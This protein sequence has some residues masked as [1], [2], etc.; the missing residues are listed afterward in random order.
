MTLT[1]LGKLVLATSLLTGSGSVLLGQSRLMKPAALQC[2]S[3]TTPLGIDS[4]QPL[5]SWKLQDSRYGARQSAYQVQVGADMNALADGKADVWDSGR[6]ASNKSVG[7]L[8]GGPSLQPEKRYYWRVRVWDQDGDEYPPSDVSWWETGLLESQHWRGKWIG[9]EEDEHRRLREAGAAWITNA[10]SDHS[11]VAG[12]THHQFRFAFDLPQ[13]AKHAFLYVTGEDSAAAWLDGKQVLKASPFPAWHQMPWKTY[14]RADITAEVH[15][16]KN[17]LA[18]DVVL[19][20]KPRTSRPTTPMSA[21]LYV[22]DSG[23]SAHIFKTGDPGWRAAL[24][25]SGNW[26]AKAFNDDSW[27]PAVPF[28]APENR[29]L[30]SEPM[31]KPWPTGSVMA[32]RRVFQVSKPIASARLYA[33]SLG[34]YEFRLNGKRVGD[35]IL[36]PGWMD[37]RQHV[38]YQVYDVTDLLKAG[39]NSI[40]VLLAPG[41]YTTPLLWFQQGYNYGDT[42]PAV[43]A[44]LRIEHPDGSLDWIATDDSWK[45]DVSPIL[46]A[47]I[48]DGETYDARRAQAGWD[49]AEFS[50]AKWKPVQ[51]I[52]PNEPKIVAQYFPPIREQSVLKAQT[53]TSPRP[54]VYIYDFGQNL[55]GVPRI[56]V[57]GPRGTDVQLRFAEVLNP[58]GSLYV[59]NLRTAKVTDHYILAGK[60]VEEYQPAF[61]FHGFRYAEISGL[62]SKPALDAVKAVVLHTDAPFTARLKTGSSM[63]NQLWSNILWGQRS[64]F[65][66][67][68][69]D[70]PQRDERLGWTGDAQ[71]FWRT[72]S[73]NMD[74]TTFSQKYA[75]DVRGTQSG[76]AMYGIFAPGALSANPGYAT[77]WSD[78]GVIVPWTSWMQTA[79]TRV[80]EENWDA[81]QKYLSAILAENPDY[82]RKKSGIGLGDWLAPEGATAVDLIAT[83]YWAYDADLMRQMAGAIGKSS[84]AR[85]YADLFAKIKAAFNQAYVHSDGFVGAVPSTVVF[86]SGTEKQLPKDPVD[87]QTGY[88]LAL[89]MNLLQ[90]SVRPLAAQRL[91]DRIAKNDWRLAT[92]FLGTPYLLEALT[93]T[94]HGDVAYRLLLNAEYPSWGYLV[95]HGATTMWE[96]WNSD[97]MRDPSMNSYNHYAYGAVADW[98]YRY[99]AGVDTLESDPGFHTIRLHPVFDRRIGSVDFSYDSVYGEIR[100]AWQV[101]GN[102]V[103]WTL[104]I[105]PNTSARLPLSAEQ[106]ATW[107]VDG[108]PLTQ[109]AKIRPVKA[110]NQYELPAGSYSFDVA[111]TEP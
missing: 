51:L 26:N 78:A 47:E 20:A 94:G 29:S 86:A 59:E 103:H 57:Q 13:S 45:A 14:K 23:G 63:I 70:C 105:P 72:A 21:T 99:A 60:G 28:E 76:T 82:L 75:A 83:A 69:T 4:Q 9:Y 27:A 101:T 53:I 7:V 32:L 49:T 93:E 106:A 2:D 104:T 37:F 11:P 18:I 8:Y 38:P 90:E 39:A 44:Q 111:L 43:R 33:T 15:S 22:E 62:P 74:L 98:I 46:F 97:Q 50:D 108:A 31:G 95:E 19:Y 109:N 3:L 36:A 65:V 56:R 80:V 91:V 34:A 79:D 96:R 54:G 84:E 89:K 87:S 30:G 67:V 42:E 92:G 102:T 81:M 66:G 58:D 48:Y 6:I 100:S 5:F 110:G 1:S 85:W 41:W 68:P 25:L 107:K 17:L 61:T 35:Q 24:N 52:R 40:G 88:V 55:S 10:A 12:D 71:V 77:G 73:Y 64:N 16:G